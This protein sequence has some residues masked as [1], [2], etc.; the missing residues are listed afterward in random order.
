MLDPRNVRE[1][2]E[3][4]KKGLENR[5]YPLHFLEEYADLDRRWRDELQTIEKL[6]HEQNQL[7]PK[8]KPTPEQLQQLKTLSQQIK[9]RQE[10]LK[11]LEQQVQWAALHIANVPHASVPVGKSEEDNREVR[12]IGTPRKFDFEPLPHDELGT[13]LG[14]LDFEKA[15]AIAGA[16]FVIYRGLGARLERALIQFML[17]THTAEHGYEEII[18]PV[19][20][21]SDSMTGTGQL[22]K[23]KEDGFAVQ[24][25]D[26]WLSPTA[27][28]QLTNMY[29]NTIIPESQL[30]L[31]LTAYTPCFRR[32]AGSYGKDVKGIIRQHQFNKV[33]LVHFATPERSFEELERLLQAAETILKKLELPYR[34]IE[35]CSGDLGFSSAKTYDIEVWFPS[36]QRYREIS[37]C[38]NF[39]DFQARRAMIRYKREKDSVVEYLHTLNGSGIAVGRAFAAILENY[40][41]ADGSI[42]IP[43]IL[44]TYMG[45]RSIPCKKE[46]KSS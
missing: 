41:Q 10:A 37:S 24:D 39:L 4:V 2:Y 22:P 28:V 32:E 38:S 36:Q 44:Q 31:K 30:P 12:R 25:T 26:F 43:A 34:V 29:R 1:H 17:D 15:A 42:Q 7:T 45:V 19:L 21:N 11:T 6:K 23:F 33:E 40:Q 35:L 5:G 8:G 27:E 14:V 3:D 20:V 13:T 9:D 18:P 16:R 46:M